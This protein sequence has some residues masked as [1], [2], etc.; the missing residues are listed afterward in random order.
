MD[1][2]EILSVIQSIIKSLSKIVL[3]GVLLLDFFDLNLF[4][5]FFKGVIGIFEESKPVVFAECL[6]LALSDISS[7]LC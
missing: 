3:C 2:T 6:N 7:Q 1:H 4:L 5:S